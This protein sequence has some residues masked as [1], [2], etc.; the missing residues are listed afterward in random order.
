LNHRDCRGLLIE[1]G[2]NG[3]GRHPCT[4]HVERIGS[5]R[6]DVEDASTSVGAAV[7]DFDNGRC[8]GLSPSRERQVGAIGARQWGGWCRGS[9]R[10]RSGCPPDHTRQLSRTDNSQPCERGRNCA[11]GCRRTHLRQRRNGEIYRSPLLRSPGGH[12]WSQLRMFSLPASGPSHRQMSRSTR[13]KY[14]SFD[15]AACIVSFSPSIPLPRAKRMV[16]PKPI[17]LAGRGNA[18]WCRPESSRRS[19]IEGGNSSLDRLEGRRQPSGCF[20][21]VTSFCLY[22]GGLMAIAPLS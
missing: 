10:L 7:V 14:R 4:L 21:L 20:H 3:D 9:H 22:G 1:Q 17:I 13:G 15:A 8:P 2:L 12:R 19:G 18:D 5:T 11:P 16:L 6:R